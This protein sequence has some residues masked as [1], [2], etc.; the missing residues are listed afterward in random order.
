MDTKYELKDVVCDDCKKV[1]NWLQESCEEPTTTKYN[2]YYSHVD[3][4]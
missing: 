2:P 1:H 3:Y 4:F